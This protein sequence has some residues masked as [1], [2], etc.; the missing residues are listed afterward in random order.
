MTSNRGK[1]M[2]KQISWAA[3]ATMMLFAHSTLAVDL[4][5]TELLPV[6]PGEPETRSTPFISA[7]DLSG[8]GY[9]EEEYL[10]SGGAN[11]YE[12]VDNAGQ[13]PEVGIRDAEVPYTS[14]ILVRKPSKAHKF[15]GTVYVEVLN[16]TAGWDGDPIWG[17]TDEYITREG[18]AYVGLT[19]K[20]VALEFLRDLWGS[21]FGTVR[22]N[23]RYATLEMPYFG[24]VWD[25]LSE[26][27]ALLK[28]SDDPDNPL[29][30]FAVERII[31]VGY[32]QSA[33]YQVTY[34]NSFHES[35]T[36]PD[37]SPV[38]DGYYIAAGG[39]RAKN[40]NR[41]T[42]LEEGLPGG[43]ARNFIAVNAPA[44]RFQTQTEVI[45]FGAYVVRQTEPAFPLIRLYEMAGGAHVD[46]ATNEGTA[47]A[48]DLGFPSFG[49]FCALDLNPIRIGFVESALMEVTDRWVRGDAQPP[50]SELITLTTDD[51]GNTIIALD[52]DGNAIGGLRPP[53]L[54]VPLGTY[55][56]NNTGGGFCFLFGGFTG[57][58][59]AEL[60]SRYRNHGQ[61]VKR[62][63]QET[64]RAVKER[65]LLSPD[66]QTLRNDAAQSAIGK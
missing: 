1:A 6:I 12:Y 35:E 63:T 51:L 46:K 59:D 60:A 26:V 45:G 37:G 39:G 38:F 42:P 50:P 19:S 23:E 7:G 22:N 17:M 41:P 36:M 43:D 30:G 66:A 27:A 47:L 48:R 62:V 3:A 20:P 25:M 56:P 21:V 58:D 15:N 5:S 4:P 10:V 44:V 16:P 13:S 54:E 52:A 49:E 55:L 57:F 24:Q 65:F 32:S 28:T 31:M 61:Y 18:A 29:Y 34:A 53:T 64:R 40:V 2:Q 8:V 14:R 11:I 9:V 33:A